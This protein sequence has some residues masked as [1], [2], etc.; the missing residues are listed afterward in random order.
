MFY[1]ITLDLEIFSSNSSHFCSILSLPV[2]KDTICLDV[3]IKGRAR[4]KRLFRAPENKNKKS[5]KHG[6]RLFRTSIGRILSICSCL[7]DPGK[8]F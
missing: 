5:D 1:G 2:G 4:L 6:R 3:Q 7:S 8:H